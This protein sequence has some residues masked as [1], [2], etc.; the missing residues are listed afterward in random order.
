MDVISIRLPDELKKIVD[1]IADETNTDRSTVIRQMIYLTR[2]MFDDRMSLEKLLDVD[3]IRERV[4]R[5]VYSRLS[6]S[7]VMKDVGQLSEEL[8]LLDEDLDDVVLSGENNHGC[9]TD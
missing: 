3:R 8:D 1:D 2:F 6:F 5:H 9:N 4:E 7:D